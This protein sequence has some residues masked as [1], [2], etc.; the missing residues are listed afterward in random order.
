[1]GIIDRV[2]RKRTEETHAPPRAVLAAAMPLSGPGVESLARARNQESVEAWQKEAW[3]YYDSVGE[4]RGPLNWIANAVSQADLFA[5]ETDPETGTVTGPTDD[6]TAQ[7]VAALVLGGQAARAQMLYILAICWQVPGESFIIIRPRPAK[8][9]VA[10]PDEWL[11]LSGTKVR[12]KGRKWTYTSPVDGMTVELREGQD[13]LIRVWSPHP[14][15]QAKADSAVRPA[16]PDL[17]EVEK[18]SMNIA[19]RLDSRLAG[20]GLLFL[21]EEMDFPKGDFSTVAASFMDYLYSAMEASLK[22]PGQASSQVPIVATVPGEFISMVNHLDLSTDFDASI[23][24]LRKDALGRLAAGL[25]MPK[26]VADGTQ[27][28]ANHWSAWQVSEDTHKIFIKPL[29][30]RIGDAI[31]E[32]WYQPVLA[33]MGVRDP[34]R[35]VLSWDVTDIIKRPDETEDLNHLYELGL[36]SDDYRRAQ[37]GVPDDAIPDEDEARLRLLRELAKISPALL[38]TP[39]VAEELGFDAPVQSAQDAVP[40]GEEDGGNVR[41]L[42][43]RVEPEPD[44]VPEGLVAA[45]ELVV[46]D[47]LSRA[48]GRLLTRQYRGQ[49]ASTPKHELHTVIPVTDVARLLE[50]SFE[51][52]DRVALAHD[53]DPV[54]M[55]AALTN[56]VTMLL[57]EGKAHD[58]LVLRW[59]IQDRV[60]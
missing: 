11:V 5:A 44:A 18:S 28:E 7:R 13:H 21:P 17:R 1:M 34:E 30:D 22:N 36:V 57:T 42:P 9:G 47:A 24:E 23:V 50:G 41:A 10:Q 29:L 37:S 27:N 15:D 40:A 26:S 49:F 25:D 19:S 46:F 32:H 12:P 31:T 43:S 6:A 4:L 58:P 20:N 45:A 35:F 54:A 16:L 33:A 53:R 14:N 39:W 2:R 38:E 48:G 59:K 3:Y 51:F 55:N 60:R 52:S 8:N 56:Y